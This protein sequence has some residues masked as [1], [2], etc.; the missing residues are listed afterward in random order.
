[1]RE[2]VHMHH[3]CA[4]HAC[5]RARACAACRLQGRLACPQDRG[6]SEWYRKYW[7]PEVTGSPAEYASYFSIDQRTGV[8]RQVRAVDREQVE[9]FSMEVRAR[10]N[11][12]AGREAT[13]RLEIKVEAKDIHPPVLRVR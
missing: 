13:A 10:E 2:H 5:A 9:Q 6:Y 8:V 7:T 11:T 1:M 12:E 3:A 4:S